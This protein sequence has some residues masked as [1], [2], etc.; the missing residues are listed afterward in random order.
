MEDAKKVELVP[1]AV[2]V[3]MP[4]A[5]PV[6][7]PIATA[8]LPIQ[9]PRA[10]HERDAQWMFFAA[11]LPRK[12][13]VPPFLASLC[14][15][16][17]AFSLLWNPNYYILQPAFWSAHIMIMVP[18]YLYLWRC[19]S[20]VYQHNGIAISRSARWITLVFYGLYMAYWAFF[21]YLELSAHPE[22]PWYDQIGNV[23]MSFVWY[24]FF[25][26]SSAVYYYTTTLLLQRT[27]ALKLRIHTITSNTTKSDFFA[28]YDAELEENRRVANRWNLVIFLA[29]LILTINLPADFLSI[30]VN[31]TYVTVPGLI[32]KSAGL[33]WYLLAICKLNYM[34][35]YIQNYLHKHHVLQDDIEELMR[36]MEVRRVGLNF[37]GLR[38]TYELLTKIAMIAFNVVLP[39]L[40]GLI[41][42][43]ILKL[44]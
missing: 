28:I 4:V 16:V 8:V 42:N 39:T 30:W 3:A 10:P 24:I 12:W 13:H 5:M 43:N 29:I 2:P 1:V 36:Y 7:V 14:N 19:K 6:A 32:I 23:F 26:A 37:F 11:G 27:A 18:T 25:A 41:S 9:H 22:D 40:Y 38:I 34:E 17:G 44:S 15:G 31:G 20:S 33:I 35:T 21:C